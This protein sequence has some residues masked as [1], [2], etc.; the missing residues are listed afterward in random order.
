MAQWSPFTAKPRASIPVPEAAQGLAA[1]VSSL[2]VTR[3]RA[4]VLSR[5]DPR[6]DFVVA[7]VAG[8]PSAEC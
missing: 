6:A 1:A 5:I 8:E 7:R 3:H 4:G 2:W